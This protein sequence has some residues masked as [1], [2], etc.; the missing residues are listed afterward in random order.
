[1]RLTRDPSWR[2]DRDWR[3]EACAAD[4]D[5]ALV[6][7]DAT[8]RW[9][10]LLLAHW[11][12]AVRE[13]GRSTFSPGT[14]ILLK[15]F[16]SGLV[17]KVLEW[18]LEGRATFGG[19][20]ERDEA[21]LLLCAMGA[22]PRVRQTVGERDDGLICLRCGRGFAR[23]E[24]LLEHQDGE[25]KTLVLIQHDEDGEDVDCEE[26]QVRDPYK[27][28]VKEEPNGEEEEEEEW[29][30]EEE[31]SK[32]TGGRSARSRDLGEG[33]KEEEEVHKC[34]ECQESFTSRSELRSHRKAEHPL[35]RKDGESHLCD[36][37][38][39]WFI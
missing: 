23:E 20:P 4:K 27:E 5:V 7:A 9:S 39:S 17:S 6:C 29:G 28:G 1:M 24:D 32:G 37:F 15:D 13:V 25:H 16:R 30:W 21:L 36:T 12:G 3:S 33:Q 10:G 31:G 38:V 19:E 18:S 8:L 14:V 35:T 2:R 11:S 26:D 22:L 34:R